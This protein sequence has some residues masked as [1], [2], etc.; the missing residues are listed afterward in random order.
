MKRKTWAGRNERLGRTLV[1][2]GHS[3]ELAVAHLLGV[4]V[5]LDVTVA[6]GAAAARREVVGAVRNGRKALRSAVVAGTARTGAAGRRHLVEHAVHEDTAPCQKEKS[7][8]P[9][10]ISIRMMRSSLQD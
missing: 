8:K 7:R 10:S 1:D 6:A 9:M 4:V 5:V 2:V 3:G